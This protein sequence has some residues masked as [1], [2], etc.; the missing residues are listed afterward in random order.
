MA[1][2]EHVEVAR[3][4]AKR[5]E[6]WRRG[7]DPR[8]TLDLGNANLNGVDLSGANLTKANLAG[9]NL[10]RANLAGADLTEANLNS[11]KLS[12]ANL[13]RANL[14]EARLQNASLAEADLSEANLTRAQVPAA[15]LSGANLTRANF[16]HANLTQAWL[17]GANV[18]G[19]NFLE[20]ALGSTELE[21]L[22]GAPT[23]KNLE[24]T[25]AG[26]ASHFETCKRRWPERWCSWEQLRSF[27]KLPLFGVSYASIVL[28]FAYVYGISW[29]NQKV[30]IAKEWARKV[31]EQPSTRLTAPA[32]ALAGTAES[33]LHRI[34]PGWRTWLALVSGILLAIASTIYRVGCPEIV[35]ECTRTAWC[36]EHNRPLVHYWATAW[37]GR[38]TRLA[39]GTFYVLGAGSAI[40]LFLVKLW[41]TSRLIWE[42]SVMG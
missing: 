34:H 39:C 40:V 12:G 38:R 8:V 3:G 9:A 23:A 4:G 36:Y 37:Q 14:S 16:D 2:E 22:R 29:Y 24:T 17:R 18:A 13:S 15:L 10:D 5:I 7:V 30:D 6:E 21:G 33:R 28:L 1:N 31:G 27:G 25:E 32:H 35:Q 11:A 20:A 26:G 41:D 42:Q 19:A